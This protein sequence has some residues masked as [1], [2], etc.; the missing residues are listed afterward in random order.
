MWGAIEIVSSVYLLGRYANWIG[1]SVSGI[2]VT[3]QA[4]LE[5]TKLGGPR[6]SK[7]T[8]VPPAPKR[9]YSYTIN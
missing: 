9:D 6:Q 5:G 3:P 8:Q 7:H 4:G 2:M 1:S